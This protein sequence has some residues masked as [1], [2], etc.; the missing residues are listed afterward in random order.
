[1]NFVFMWIEIYWCSLCFSLIVVISLS[2]N[3]CM[4]TQPL[5]SYKLIKSQKKKWKRPFPF[6]QR[7]E[8]TSVSLLLE[9]LC[10]DVCAVSR[11]SSLLHQHPP[12]FNFINMV[13]L[14][15]QHL[16][17]KASCKTWARLWSAD[18]L[19]SSDFL[20][21]KTAPVLLLSTKEQLALF[22]WKLKKCVEQAVG[23]LLASNRRRSP[24]DVL[25]LS[26]WEPHEEEAAWH[27]SPWNP[28]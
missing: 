12:Q 11:L 20:K 17:F 4:W 2:L 8:D 1:M 19:S 26:S 27:L 7:T 15:F 14:F 28:Q 22:Y 3:H 10:E 21:I 18:T 25:Y 6:L 13:K 23:E 16:C 9:L 24:Q 5:T